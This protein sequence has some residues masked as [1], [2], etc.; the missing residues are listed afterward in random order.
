M[1]NALI[2]CK[3]GGGK[4]VNSTL[5]TAPKRKKNLLICTDKSAFL[6]SFHSEPKRK[7]F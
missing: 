3:S 7:T 1:A 2:Y 4:T 6:D 5:V